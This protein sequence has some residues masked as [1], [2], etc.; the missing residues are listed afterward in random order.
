[1][2]EGIVGILLLLVITAVVLMIVN[3]FKIGVEVDGFGSAFIAAVVIAIVGGGI[4]WLLNILGINLLGG[5]VGMIA[6][7]IVVAIVLMIADRFVSGLHVSSFGGAFISAI[8][9]S[10]TFLFFIFILG[11]LR[12]I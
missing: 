12:V 5:V 6:V 4:V 11:V 2:F 3:R 7:L 1:M 9:V 8:V 10:I